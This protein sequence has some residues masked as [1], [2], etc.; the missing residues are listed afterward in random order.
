MLELSSDKAR[1]DCVKMDR[2]IDSY[3]N[4]IRSQRNQI[5]RIM[6]LHKKA[7]EHLNTL[8]RG[9]QP[10]SNLSVLVSKLALLQ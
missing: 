9:E 8:E 10:S 4:D 5:K 3:H 1:Q 2:K 6:H 7:K